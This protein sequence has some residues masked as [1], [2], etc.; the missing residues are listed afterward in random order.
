MSVVRP[1]FIDTTTGEITRAGVSDTVDN[2]AIEEVT[3]NAAANGGA[4]DIL[5]GSPVKSNGAGTVALAQADSTANAQI[6]G[7]A[8]ETI[9]EDNGTGFIGTSGK[10]VLTTGEWDAITGGS[11]GLTP[12]QKYWLDPVT[13]G[14]LVATPPSTDTQVIAPVGIAKSTTI[15]DIDIDR[16][17]VL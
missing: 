11:G 17:V 5:P 7:L 10:I 1:L 8:R 9:P 14:K 4:D 3:N 16:I 2:P 15:L 12:T 13:A 6:I